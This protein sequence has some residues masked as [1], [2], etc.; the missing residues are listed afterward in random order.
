MT[1]AR[2][3]FQL[4]GEEPSRELTVGA[5]G[6]VW[7][8]DIPFV[9]V[10]GPAAYAAFAEP[11]WVKVAWALRV[12]PRGEAGSRLSVEIRVDA[13][14]EASWARFTRYW[15]LIGPGSHFIRQSLLA[16]LRR[17]FG[18]PRALVETRRA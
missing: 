7:Q 10:D 13:T 5:I 18:A 8:L 9:H 4:L 11:G 12:Q 3:G 14:D 15:H 2:P 6:Q 1:R 16:S 17:R